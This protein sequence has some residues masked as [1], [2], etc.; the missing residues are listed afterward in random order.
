M[1]RNVQLLLALIATIAAAQSLKVK[2][3]G[4]PGTPG[5]RFGRIPCTREHSAWHW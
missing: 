3:A 4:A 2:S 5:A 1:V